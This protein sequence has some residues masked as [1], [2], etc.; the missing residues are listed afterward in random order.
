MSRWPIFLLPIVGALLAIFSLSPAVVAQVT[1]PAPTPGAEL[2]GVAPLPL[3][4]ERRAAFEAYLADA[5]NR[6]GVPGASVAVVQDGEVVYLQGFGVKAVGGDAPVGPNTLFAIAST[7]KAFTSAM[8][9]TLVDDGQLSWDTPVVDMLPDFA[10]ADPALTPRVTLADAFCMCTGIPGRTWQIVFNANRLTPQRLIASVADMPLT[11]PFGEEF[12]YNNQI[13]AVGGYAAA[14]AA[15]G[16]PRDLNHAYQ[17]AMRDRILNPI[18]MTRS[19]FTLNQVLADGDYTHPHATDLAGN[20]QPISL[21]TTAHLAETGAGPSGA[22]WSSARDMARWLQ[23]QLAGGVAPD[24]TRVVSTANLLRTRAPRVPIPPDP[25]TLDVINDVSQYYAMGWEVGDYKGQPLIHHSGSILGFNSQVT[26]LPDANL[27]VVILT[28]GGLGA[29]PFT[30]AARFRLLELLFNQPEEYDAV[31]VQSLEQDSS[32]FTAFQ[33][34]LRPI[35]PAAVAPHQ[36]HYTNPAMGDVNLSIQDGKLV[37]DTGGYR[38]ELQAQVDD[39]G[40]VIGYGLIEPPLG[41]P[42]LSVTF[43]HGSDG[44]PEMV[45]TAQGELPAADSDSEAPDAENAPATTYVFRQP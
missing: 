39:T 36:G 23:T 30:L 21:L 26:F 17:Q 40:R 11:T 3:T 41:G 2:R 27:G 8:A 5:M 45:V 29:K 13:Y 33:A 12:Q 37:L 42:G 16:A 10:V 4:G 19:T 18:G 6:L 44:R 31:A 35:E 9:A 32:A 28:N 14:V 43:R 15:G 24:G 25:N 7:T 34:Q 38:S 22:L 20:T 1:A